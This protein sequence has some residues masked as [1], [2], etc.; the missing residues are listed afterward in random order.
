[1]LEYMCISIN[2]IM[3]NPY[4]NYLNEKLLI[5]VCLDVEIIKQKLKD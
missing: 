1:M 5:T 4:C 3:N 2:E